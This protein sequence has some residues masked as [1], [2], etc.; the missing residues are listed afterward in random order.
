MKIRRFKESDA[1]AVSELIRTTE[2]ITNSKD[3]PQEII[4]TLCARTT[5]EW[6][7]HRASWTHFYVAEEDGKI[8]GCGAVGPYWDREDEC[9]FFNIF[10]HPD[11]QGQ[12]I[13]RAIIE[14][15]EADE[16][17]LRSKRV[18]IAAS[19]TGLDFYRKL[20]YGFKDGGDRLDDEMLYRLEKF[21]NV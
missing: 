15:L 13:G 17:Y 21:R 5:P 18:E 11:R 16:I 3:Y 2:R 7:L 6:V 19:I 9:S 12:G 14:T 8:I 10:V 4:D 1:H 20:G